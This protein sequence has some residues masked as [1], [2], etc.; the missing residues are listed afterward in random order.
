MIERRSFLKILGLAGLFPAAVGKETIA[1]SILPKPAKLPKLARQPKVKA[2]KFPVCEVREITWED[3]VLDILPSGDA[4]RRLGPG[5]E[6]VTWELW[7][8]PKSRPGNMVR[9]D[10]GSVFTLTHYDKERKLTYKGDVVLTSWH[11]DDWTYRGERAFLNATFVSV[12]PVQVV[13]GGK[14]VSPR[15][16]IRFA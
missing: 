7:V 6:T 12:S 4:W 8:T 14:P 5:L 3:G 10:V 1:E 9:S 2:R 13:Y 16:V 15:E 11:L